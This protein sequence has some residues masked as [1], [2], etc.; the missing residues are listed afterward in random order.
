MPRQQNLYYQN[1][2]GALGESL[3]RALFGDSAAAAEQ[4]KEMAQAALTARTIHLR[5]K[6]AGGAPGGRWCVKTG[7][8]ADGSIIYFPVDG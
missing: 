1:P 5:V 8:N 7:R 3:G 4:R 2:A 6:C